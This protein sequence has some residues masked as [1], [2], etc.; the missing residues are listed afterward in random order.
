MIAA[1]IMC[2][3]EVNGRR[4]LKSETV[5]LMC[6]VPYKNDP[7]IGRALGWDMYSSHSSCKGTLTSPRRT[8]CHTGYTGP[9]MVIDLDNRLAIILLAH[10]CHPYD[11]GSMKELR[12]EVAD[13]VAGAI[14]R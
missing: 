1:A 9:S 3:G 14:I 5:Q 4:I 8:L 10:R 13:I 2:G 6:T 7:R 12:A 11:V